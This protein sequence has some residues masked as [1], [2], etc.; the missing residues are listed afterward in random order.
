MTAV[1]AKAGHR[2][3]QGRHVRRYRPQS[4]AGRTS[5]GMTTVWLNADSDW[6]RQG[7]EFPVASAGHIDHETVDLTDFLNSIG[8]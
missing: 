7:P 1:V 2:P 6:A 5:L 8:I 4:G 3:G